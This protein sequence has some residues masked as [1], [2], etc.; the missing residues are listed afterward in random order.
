M[1]KNYHSTLTQI[2]AL[3][4]AADCTAEDTER[5]RSIAALCDDALVRSPTDEA[6]AHATTHPR[7]KGAA[8]HWLRCDAVF[9]GRRCVKGSGHADGHEF[10]K[11]PEANDAEAA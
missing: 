8:P 10:S 2:A 11:P 1:S 6:L 9:Y 4:R 5:L 7:E 3:A